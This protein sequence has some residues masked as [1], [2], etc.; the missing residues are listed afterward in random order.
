MLTNKVAYLF[1]SYTREKELQFIC[2]IGGRVCNPRQQQY[3][4]IVYL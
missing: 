4:V 1:F 3:I 2:L